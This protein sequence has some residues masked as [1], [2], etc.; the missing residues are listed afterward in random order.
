[1]SFPFF[2][3]FSPQISL[4]ISLNY[5]QSVSMGNAN[6]SFPRP[7][8]IGSIDCCSSAVYTW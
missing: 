1:M 6:L 8:H 7:Q 2:F 4:F 3:F 5:T